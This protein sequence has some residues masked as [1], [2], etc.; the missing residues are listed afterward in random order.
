MKIQK[1]NKNAGFSL[2]ELISVVAVMVCLSVVA[3]PLYGS[4][5][6]EAA[7]AADA[8]YINECYRAAALVTA[9]DGDYV[10]AVAFTPTGEVLVAHN[11]Y[12]G[13]DEAN[14]ALK[15]GVDLAGSTGK[16]KYVFCGGCSTSIV[17]IIGGMQEFQSSTL[18][19]TTTAHGATFETPMGTVT[20]VEGV[21]IGG[22]NQNYGAWVFEVQG[23]KASW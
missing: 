17:A 9:E 12:G 11:Y 10:R 4:Y 20:Y 5:T 16:D 19:S 2:V 15:E 7:E 18:S 1:I 22:A 14:V 13:D 8:T 6:A 23:T 3:V 21:R